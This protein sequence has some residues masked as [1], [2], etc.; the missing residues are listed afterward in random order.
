MVAPWYDDLVV[1]NLPNENP[2]EGMILLRH[3][4]GDV[5]KRVRKDNTLAEE[6]KFE[7]DSAGKVTRMLQHSNYSNRIMPDKK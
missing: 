2:D 5:F 4:S 6:I 3:V 7:R 1:L